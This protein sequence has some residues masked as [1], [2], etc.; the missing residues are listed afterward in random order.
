M[1]VN[2]NVTHLVTHVIGGKQ[3]E[4]GLSSVLGITTLKVVELGTVCEGV[5]PVLRGKSKH[6]GVIRSTGAFRGVRKEEFHTTSEEDINNWPER[7]SAD[8]VFCDDRLIV[9]IVHV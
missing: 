6:V 2:R 4:I 3:P 8:K 9:T 1:P 7:S 5:I